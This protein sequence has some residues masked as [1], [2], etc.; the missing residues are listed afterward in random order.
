MC[1]TVVEEVQKLTGY[2]RVMVYK[3]HDDEHGEVVSEIRRSDLE[4]YLGLHYPATDI[5]QAARFLFKQNRV[6]IIVDCN[7]DSVPVIQSQEL[8]QPLCLVNS[9]LRVCI[10]FFFVVVLFNFVRV[11][12]NDRLRLKLT[13]FCTKFKRPDQVANTF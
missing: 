11:M 7:P 1:D 6:R 4:P 8:K 2:D 3:F 9:T 10:L 13:I 12:G 5:P